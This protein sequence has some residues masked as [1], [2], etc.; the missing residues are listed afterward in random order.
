M[1]NFKAVV[2]K[3]RADGFYPVYIRIV[4]RSRMGYIKTSK[5]VTDKQLGKSG[6]I[7]DAVVNDFC[8]REILRYSDIMNRKDVSQYSVGELIEY[9]TNMDEDTSFSE[10]ADAFIARMSAEGHERN[11]KNYRLAV[12]HLQRFLGTTEVMFSRLSTS[13]LNKWIDSLSLT[14][15]A[16]EMYPTCVRQ[17]F[18]KALVELNDEERGIIRIKYNPWLKINIPK[19]DKTMKL[20][21]SAEACRE[22]FNRPLP[23]TKM[24]ASTPELGRDIAMLIFCLGGIN[25]V[26]L[27]NL[28][29]E[30]YHDG[31]IAYKRA[32]TRHSRSDE[33][34]MEMRVEPFIQDTF[35]K[36]LADE[37]DEYLFVFHS[38]YRDSDSFNAGVNIGIRKICM[39]MGMKKEQFYCGYTFRHTW[40]TI[41]QNDCDAN[42]SDVA[43]GLNHSH[44]Y[45]V[46]RG[47][48]K[49]DF[50]PAWELNAKIID[51]VFFSNKRSKQGKAR[52]LE[53]SGNKLFRISPKMMI[54][55]RAYF[56]GEVVAELT[57]IGFSNIN[58]V[59]TSLTPDLPKNMPVGC[60]VQF[61]ITNCDSKQEM[62]YERSKGKGF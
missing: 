3:K 29:K 60:T 28:K 35:N 58:Q 25:T 36:Y 51:F 61:R 15:R 57:N 32:K 33:A 46:T 48:V 21:I 8:A 52:D 42:I 55:A 20:A 16:K 10:F 27:Y 9:L 14:N 39:D 11:A 31:I 47:Y 45:N 56:K 23:K 2:R 44:G 12:D 34:Y 50:T 41:A 24:L 53:E 22:F 4:H 5:I 54:R 43:F 59:I 18:K 7:K 62:V 19:S 37:N 17:I 49:I 13:T 26:D 6:E 30:D 38:R 1:A 40:A